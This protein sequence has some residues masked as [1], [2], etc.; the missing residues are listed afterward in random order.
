MDGNVL[1][2]SNPCLRNLRG[3]DRLSFIGG[4]LVVRYNDALVSVEGLE[5]I[6]KVGELYI[7]GNGGVQYNHTLT[8]LIALAEYQVAD[9]EKPSGRVQVEPK[10]HVRRA[11]SDGSGVWELEDIEKKNR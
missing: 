11:T 10:K 2:Q 9:G 1:I 8:S 4:D 6:R 3:L 7:Y 5:G